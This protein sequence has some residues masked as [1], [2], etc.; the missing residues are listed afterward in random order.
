MALR[1]VRPGHSDGLLILVIPFV[2]VLAGV[3]ADR[4]AKGIRLPSRL[5]LPLVALLLIVQPLVLSAQVVKMFSQPDTREIMLGW[6]HSSIPQGSRFFSERRLQ[7]PLGHA[8]YPD[9][10]HS[11]H[12]AASL[13]DSGDYDYMIYSDAKAL[14]C[15]VPT[16]LCQR[17]Q[18][19]SSAPTCGGSMRH[20]TES[21]GFSA[22]P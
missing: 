6:V 14:T 20:S 21:R 10:A 4:V 15:C 2:A 3:G 9:Y 19:K 16:R 22:R 7:R 18:S 17:R 1:T 8:L 12:Y 11:A 5:S 13:P